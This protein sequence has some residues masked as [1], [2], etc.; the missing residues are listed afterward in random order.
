MGLSSPRAEARCELTTD[1]HTIALWHFNEGQGQIAYDSSGNGRDLT[2]GPTD[3]PEPQ[4]PAWIETPFGHGLYFTSAEEDY[5]NGIGPSTFPT[6][7]LSVELWVNLIGGTGVGGGAQIFTAGF[8]NCFVYVEAFIDRIEVGVGDGH[9]WE[10]SEAYL[11][12]TELDDGAWHYIAMTYDGLA[13]RTFLDGSEVFSQYESALQLASPEDYKVGGRPYNDFLEGSMDEIRLSDIARTPEEI[14]AHWSS[15]QACLGEPGAQ[16]E[17]YYAGRPV[18]TRAALPPLP[19]P[20]GNIVVENL[21]N[22]PDLFQP[23][24]EQS[25]LSFDLQVLDLPGLPSGQFDFKGRVLWTIESLETR[26]AVR[27]IVAE[28]PLAQ[29]GMVPV[30]LLWDGT[31]SQGRALPRNLYLY[32][33]TVQLLRTKL[34]HNRTQVKDEVISPWRFSSLARPNPLAV[35]GEIH[36][37]YEA[38]VQLLED[39][40]RDDPIV[41]ELIRGGLRPRVAFTTDSGVLVQ[42]TAPSLKIPVGSALPGDLAETVARK[43]LAERSELVGIDPRAVTLS[44]LAERTVGDST[45]VAFRPVFQDKPIIAPLVV[46]HVDPEN[47]VSYYGGAALPTTVVSAGE[48]FS[49]REI[50]RVNGLACAPRNPSSRWHRTSKGLV[51]AVTFD[52]DLELIVG[53]AGTGAILHRQPN[54]LY[55]DAVEAYPEGGPRYYARP[56]LFNGDPLEFWHYVDCDQPYPAGEEARCFGYPA[57]EVSEFERKI[58]GKEPVSPSWLTPMGAWGVYRYWR[59]LFASLGPSMEDAGQ[60][61]APNVPIQLMLHTTPGFEPYFSTDDGMI[62]IYFRSFDLGSSGDPFDDLHNIYHEAEHARFLWGL[63]GGMP[64]IDAHAFPIQEGHAQVASQAMDDWTI[65]PSFFDRYYRGYDPSFS[66]PTT[67][68]TWDGY[69]TLAPQLGPH[70]QGYPVNNWFDLLAVDFPASQA[71]AGSF[72]D[73]W[74]DQLHSS[75]SVY[76]VLH[77]MLKGRYIPMDSPLYIPWANALRQAAGQWYIEG[78]RPDIDLF[79]QPEI[80]LVTD[81]TRALHALGFWSGPSLAT[82]ELLVPTLDSPAAV[83]LTVGGEKQLWVVY[84]EYSSHPDDYGRFYV[85]PLTSLP[86]L[87]PFAADA[88]SDHSPSIFRDRHGDAVILWQSSLLSS[89]NKVGYFKIY[90]DAGNGPPGTVSEAKYIDD[91]VV[92]TSVEPA[93]AVFQ[94]YDHFIYYRDDM[95]SIVVYREHAGPVLEIPFGR[96]LFGVAASA[97]HEGQCELG[98][99]KLF[100]AGVD[101][102]GRVALYGIDQSYHVTKTVATDDPYGHSPPLVLKADQTPSLAAVRDKTPSPYVSFWNPHKLFVAWVID[103]LVINR[104]YYLDRNCNIGTSVLGADD[105]VPPVPQAG[106]TSGAGTKLTEIDLDVNGITNH[107]KMLLMLN[108]DIAPGNSYVSLKLVDRTSDP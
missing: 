105:P 65:G 58:I 60:H 72:E 95:Q 42:M 100:V 54:R 41:E 47:H 94:G 19:G 69:W 61:W 99:Q 31:D 32:Q 8:I 26:R 92:R 25:Q 52:C 76:G 37:G 64:Q 93:G 106:I 53:H 75:A 44:P 22:E 86:R 87:Y 98:Q 30:R 101:D 107:Y 80:G 67:S 49:A 40:Q 103:N 1:A 34:S 96:S 14:W 66:T 12:A 46:V 81:A 3:S 15:A 33:A 73:V 9:T 88:R 104:R 71:P 17:V 84:R 62:H 45:V 2:L 5:A 74:M 43:F 83:Q 59:D 29:T 18:D 10:V 91:P 11:D 6:N 21:R 78:Q 51:A 38:Y 89:L 55:A 57:N 68:P 70:V 48:S 24:A 50:A 36:A 39:G 77:T 56:A 7:Q 23:P 13:L 90:G 79:A 85:H 35:L 102:A 97:T 4:D 28:V 82:T 20:K 16:P 108:R 27:Q 63:G